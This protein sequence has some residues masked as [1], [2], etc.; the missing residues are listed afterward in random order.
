MTLKSMS[1]SMSSTRL[2]TGMNA[3]LIKNTNGLIKIVCHQAAKMCLNFSASFT[4]KIRDTTV[5]II[6]NTTAQRIPRIIP[7]TATNA[8]DAAL[9]DPNNSIPVK[10]LA[11]CGLMN[12]CV[13]GKIIHANITTRKQK[14]R[15]ATLHF[16]LDFSR[17]NVDFGFAM[18]SM[19][20]CQL[21]LIILTL[22]RQRYPL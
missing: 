15:N 9:V 18:R 4:L 14:T 6:L 16:G 1:A 19:R 17:V 5:S 12:F 2:K 21:S 3:V 20:F 13:N 7:L 8:I 22:R 10:L 11:Y